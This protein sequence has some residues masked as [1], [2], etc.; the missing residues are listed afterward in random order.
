MKL[1]RTKGA[2]WFWAGWCIH[3]DSLKPGKSEFVVWLCWNIIP[4]RFGF[5]FEIGGTR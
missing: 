3:L 2:R 4:R 1:L 5:Y